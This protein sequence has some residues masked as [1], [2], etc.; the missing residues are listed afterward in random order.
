MVGGGPPQINVHNKFSAN[1]NLLALQKK[2]EN[3]IYPSLKDGQRPP[4][5]GVEGSQRT[6]SLIQAETGHAGDVTPAPDS[7]DSKDSASDTTR[8]GQ[9][10]K[11]SHRCARLRAWLTRGASSALKQ[12]RQ[13]LITGIII[14]LLLTAVIVIAQQAGYLLT[15][16]SDYMN[17]VM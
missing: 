13:S 15:H 11:G 16:K 3:H 9:L 1:A 17:K 7:G 4:G 14:C 12:V 6:E 8:A 10:H 5:G 2:T